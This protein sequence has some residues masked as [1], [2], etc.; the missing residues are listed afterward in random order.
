MNITSVQRVLAVFLVLGILVTGGLASAQSIAHESHHSHHQ[1][2]THGTV[3]CSWMCAAG[4]GL[5][6][7]VAPSVLRVT[8]G[9]LVE[10]SIP[11]VISSNSFQAIQYR[12]PP[13]T[14]AV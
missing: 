12:G 7:D 13:L 5:G 14:R 1:K 2:A 10:Q 8:A 4:Q 11:Q 3:L 9:E 6:G